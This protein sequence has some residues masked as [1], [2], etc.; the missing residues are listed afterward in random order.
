[1][2]S[3]TRWTTVDYSMLAAVGVVGAVIFY[4]A[5]FV[6]DFF[7]VLGPLARP[8]SVGLW[9]TAAILAATLIRKPGAAFAGE[10]LAAF[11]ESLLPT[12]AGFV[13]LMYGILQ[14]LMAELGYYILRYRRWDTLAGTIAGALSGIGEVLA[15]IIYYREIAGESVVETIGGEI[16]S[17]ALA[18]VA[19]YWLVANMISGALYGSIA[20]TIARAV[21]R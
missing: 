3:N 10:V 17:T 18:A 20:A 19:V 4:A 11:I 5:W 9:F 2:A 7:S 1:M 15:S 16:G 6:W 12:S 8:L 21:K 13:N 14:G